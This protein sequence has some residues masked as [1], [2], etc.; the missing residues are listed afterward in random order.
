[1]L[2]A[3][4]FWS[5]AIGSS[6][7]V[8]ASNQLRNEE[9]F[10]ENRYYSATLL[11]MGLFVVPAV[12]YL[13]I[14]YPGWETMYA[15]YPYLVDMDN[16]VSGKYPVSAG[17]ILVSIAV[18]FFLNCTLG[19]YLAFQCI[20]KDKMMTAHALW[21]FGY[22]MV[23]VVMLFGWDG[24]AWERMTYAGSW[25]EWHQWKTLGGTNTYELK[26]FFSTPVFSDLMVLAVIVL[27]PV[28]YV[29]LKWPRN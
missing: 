28:G 26:D 7:A 2:Q 16:S 3:D 10:F 9:K 4:F 14:V 13:T 12:T 8:A 25:Q 29:Y 23:V 22:L 21:I 17:L 27:P 5:F 11:F 24:T 19:F 1:M 15:I 20:K 6:F 18:S